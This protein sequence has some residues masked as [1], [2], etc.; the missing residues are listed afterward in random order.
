MLAG[1]QNIAWNA[2][3]GRWQDVTNWMTDEERKWRQR[4][5]VNRLLYWF[6]LT[7]SRITENTPIVAFK[8]AT[9]DR[10]DALLAE[11]MDPVFKTVWQQANME[12]VVDE[13][14]SVLIPCGEVYTVSRLDLTLGD[15]RPRIGPAMLQGQ[16]WEGNPLELYAEAVPYG[17]DGEPLAQLHPDGSYEA[18]GEPYLEPEGQIVVDVL[19]PLQVRGEWG[20]RPWHRKA[21][22]MFYSF[23]PIQDIRDRY[24]VDVEAEQEPVLGTSTELG[25][26]L[27]GSG[28]FGSMSQ[29]SGSEGMI[30]NFADGFAGVW[31]M[32]MRPVPSDPVLRE[33]PESPGGRLMI[34]TRTKL[35][36]DGPREARYRYTSPIRK[37]SF[38]RV[39]GRPSG[40]SPQEPMNP[41]QRAYNKGWGQIL[42]HRDL[43]TN[44]FIVIDQHTGLKPKDITNRP[45]TI[46]KVVRRANIPPLEMVAPPR[47]GE[48]VFRTQG[49]LREE[50]QDFGSI[51][52]TEGRPPTL[53]ASGELVKELRA[54]SD[55]YLSATARRSVIE[56]ARM[57]EDW[58][59][60]LQ[61]SWDQEKVLTYAGEDQAA[62]TVVVFPEMFKQGRVNVVPD[63]ESAMPEGRGERQAK[64]I[65][66]YRDGVFGPPGTPEAARV[67]LEMFRFPHLGRAA[68]WGRVDGVTARQENGRLAMGEPA[69]AIPLFPWYSDE[70]HLA[71]HEEYMKAPEFVGLDPMIQQAFMVHWQAHMTRFQAQLAA[72][73]ALQQQQTGAEG[74]E[75]GPPQQ[76]AAGAAPAASAA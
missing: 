40:T 75:G 7:H 61:V 18:T 51:E 4:P 2:L 27:M 48:E 3:A 71:I 46:L 47:L 19:N 43:S 12:D 26:V 59:A 76:E 37:Y 54:N 10:I 72:Q 68:Q 49:L 13:R 57:V 69:E 63:I 6:T 36:Y 58:I 60:L 55:R 21:W 32:W 14:A 73:A 53:D 25:R 44:P 23:M 38:I 66:L 52:G 35:L 17:E 42:Q 30:T 65:Q 56:D 70:I 15:L 62:T 22:H 5:V 11:V 16:D 39:P 45:G 64:M 74:G 31:T 9:L 29:R 24:G 67:Y 8:P 20:N 33:T 34:F 50:L 41:L 28:Y 1:Q